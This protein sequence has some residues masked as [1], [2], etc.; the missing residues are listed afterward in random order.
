MAVQ[1]QWVLLAPSLTFKVPG[2]KNSSPRRPSL[3]APSSSETHSGGFFI[4]IAP[5]VSYCPCVGILL[6]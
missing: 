6:R 5:S 2:K 1:G 4:G 3:V